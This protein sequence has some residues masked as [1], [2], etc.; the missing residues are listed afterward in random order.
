MTKS[1][2]LTK[3]IQELL[4]DNISVFLYNKEQLEGGY[5]GMV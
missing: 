1:E 2:F 3:A 5:G 4:G